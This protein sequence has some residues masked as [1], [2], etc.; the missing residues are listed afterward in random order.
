MCIFNNLKLEFKNGIIFKVADT[1]INFIGLHRFF[2]KV[3]DV[4]LVLLC[5]ANLN[6]YLYNENIVVNAPLLKE[7]IEEIRNKNYGSIRFGITL[8]STPECYDYSIL[9]DASNVDDKTVDYNI[10]IEAK[11]KLYKRIVSVSLGCGINGYKHNDIAKAVINKLNEL[12][13]KY[14]IDFTLVL[15]SEEIKEMYVFE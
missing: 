1:N 12:V 9:A 8:L 6:L 11:K 4:I 3:D 5:Y 2:I 13:N 15:P 7:L 10:F 14:D